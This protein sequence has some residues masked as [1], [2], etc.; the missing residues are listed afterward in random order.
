MSGTIDPA[1]A[2]Q[3]ERVLTLVRDALGDD[4]FGAYLHGSAVSGGLKPWSDLDVLA[5]GSRP[6]TPAEKRVLVDGLMPISGPRAAAGPARHLEVSIVVQAAVRPWRYPPSLDFQYG[7]W[8]LGEFQ[9]GNLTP[10]PEPNPDVAVLL[11]AVR[12]ASRTLVGPPV[13]ELVDPVPRGDLDRAMRDGVPGLLTELA[14]DTANVLLTLARI[15]MTL[16]TGEIGPKDVAA[17]W[18]LARL[19]A[20]DGAALARARAIYTGDAP[21]SWDDLRAAADADAQAIVAEIERVPRG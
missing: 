13:A 12:L 15:W 1:V 16:A 18:A 19:V 8:L 3:L 5:V 4:L 10:W 7:D 17:H 20:V 21:D 11:T 6:M 9:A 2:A 14:D